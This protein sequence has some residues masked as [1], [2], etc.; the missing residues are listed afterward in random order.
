MRESTIWPLREQIS[1]FSKHQCSWWIL[2]KY[3][4]YRFPDLTLKRFSIKSQTH[5][6]ESQCFVL[7]S[8]SLSYWCPRWH[9]CMFRWHSESL[10]GSFFQLQ[11]ST[12]QHATQ[13]VQKPRCDHLLIFLVWNA[14]RDFIFHIYPFR[15]LRIN[16]LVLVQHIMLLKIVFLYHRSLFWKVFMLHIIKV[17]FLFCLTRL[18]SEQLVYILL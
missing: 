16:K 4:Q 1:H 5:S 3:T 9:Q 2:R 13:G 10:P 12:T 17:Q 15:R 6:D 14:H 8:T 7:V 18:L 11:P